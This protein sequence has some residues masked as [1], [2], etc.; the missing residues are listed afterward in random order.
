MV[1]YRSNE[2][3]DA[4]ILRYKDMVYRI[5]TLRTNN[6]AD[7]D[8]IFQE[9]FLRLVRHDAP[10]EGEE[11]IKAWL[12]RVTINCCNSLHTSSFRK[13]T[14]SYEETIGNGTDENS[15]NAQ[16]PESVLLVEDEYHETGGSSLLD[17]VKGLSPSYRDVVYLFYYE[18]LPIKRICE[19]LKTSEGAVKTRLSR[20]RNILKDRLTGESN[21]E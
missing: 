11:H 8:D 17:A 15:A 1:A 21:F 2:Q 9:V 13:K 10:L 20:A 16:T 4:I 12:I 18:E 14:V 19:I 3:L 6:R 7:A 5:A